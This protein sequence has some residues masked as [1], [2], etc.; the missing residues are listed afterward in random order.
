MRRLDSRHFLPSPQTIKS[1]RSFLWSPPSSNIMSLPAQTVSPKAAPLPPV[2]SEQPFTEAQ[3]RT[4][5]A[6][7]DTIIP[8]VKPNAVAKALTEA[9]V[10]DNEYSTAISTLKGRSETSNE[11]IATAYLH[12][13]ASSIPE[14]RL[15]MHRLFGMY[16]PEDARKQLAM[17]LS[18]L[19]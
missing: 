18:I 7:A 16:M 3:W 17:A 14:F 1:V 15:A 6:I 8:S 19:E 12:E 5:L 11:E 4:L 13:N 9:P 2:P 10:T